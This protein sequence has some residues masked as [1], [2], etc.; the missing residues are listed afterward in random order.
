[1]FKRILQTTT[2]LS[3][4]VLRG[5]IQGSG[6]AA[7]YLSASAFLALLLTIG[8]LVYAWDIDQT[9]WYRA[10]GILQGIELDEIQRAERERAAEIHFGIVL[11]ER[12]RQRLEDEYR[13]DVRQTA[14]SLPSPPEVPRTEAP[15]VPSDAERISDYERRIAADRAKAES[16]GL[17]N[18]IETLEGMPPDQAKEVIRRFWKETPQRALQVLMGME[19]RTRQ[20]ILNAM[21]ATVDEE[22]KD[23]T[24][25]LQR[26]GDGEPMTSI[27]N[28]AAREP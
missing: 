22:L 25:I 14:R 20:R 6:A 10:L 8:Y 27:I 12:V 21:Q 5:I 17:A 16:E 15:A 11:E 9:R 19:E 18:L 23:L 24:E 26:I 3:K 1:M 4:A 7:L 13:Q 2:N 28:D